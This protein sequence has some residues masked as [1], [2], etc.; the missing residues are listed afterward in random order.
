MAAKTCALALLTLISFS[1]PIANS[2][3][4]NIPAVFNFGDSNSDT[5]TLVSAGIESLNPPNGQNYFHTPSGRYC[6]GRLIVD[7][8]STYCFIHPY[9]F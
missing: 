4:F 2:V 7:F 8:L 6:D 3:H 1:L 9:S 5:G